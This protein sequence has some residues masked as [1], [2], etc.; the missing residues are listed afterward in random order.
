MRTKATAAHDPRHAQ[1]LGW[2][3]DPNSGFTRS[4]L[5]G[6]TG[7][8]SE[9]EA[10]AAWPSVRRQVWS[11]FRRFSVPPAAVMFDQVTIDSCDTVLNGWHAPVFPLADALAAVAA[12]RR[13]LADFWERDRVGATGIEDFLEQLEEDLA[14]IEAA[15]HEFGAATEF[16]ER[17]HLGSAVRYGDCP[18][19]PR[20]TRS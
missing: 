18:D 13:N 12:D 8:A 9:A 11:E 1:W 10:R 16:I 2:W 5:T 6:E 3:S 20:D 4:L 7:F 17:P 15:A 14:I 19:V